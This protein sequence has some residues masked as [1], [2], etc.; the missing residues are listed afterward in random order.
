MRGLAR[1]RHGYCRQIWCLLCFLAL[2]TGVAVAQG[3]EVYILNKPLSAKMT[4]RGE[5]YGSLEEILKLAGV[6][7]Q[8][9]GGG[10]VIG[11]AGAQGGASGASGQGPAG[12]QASWRGKVIVGGK[13]FPHLLAR[14]G[15]FF[16]PVKEFASLL[17]FKVIVNDQTRIIDVIKG[18][19]GISQKLV[20]TLNEAARKSPQYYITS[21][22]SPSAMT[23][24]I[25]ESFS[26]SEREVL[27]RHPDIREYLSLL[28][29]VTK[30]LTGKAEL[31]REKLRKIQQ[32]GIKD[33]DWGILSAF[34]AELRKIVGEAKEKF[35]RITPPTDFSRTHSNISRL[36]TSLEGMVTILDR[37]VAEGPSIRVNRARLSEYEQEMAKGYG[38]IMKAS[39]EYLTQFN[40][41]W[42]SFLQKE[43]GGAPAST[44]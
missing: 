12:G 40:G 25:W 22:V 32:E 17:G 2:L 4:S 35:A 1:T 31:L 20:E 44:P 28:F 26:Q 27:D 14:E 15:K 7:Y 21:S 39:G 24:E 6:P 30:E 8:E 37:F 34:Q 29:S 13:S 43:S 3:Y 16:V 38:E 10:F 11:G 23:R 9:A 36:L 19:S 42:Q 33:E 18:S 41:E 5:I